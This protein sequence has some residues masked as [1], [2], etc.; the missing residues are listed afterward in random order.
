MRTRRDEQPT[1]LY[2]RVTKQF[3]NSRM[4]GQLPIAFQVLVG[5]LPPVTLAIQFPFS[6]S[7]SRSAGFAKATT[8]LGS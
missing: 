8:T 1:A 6:F 2:L 7:L 5:Q 4:Q 3:G